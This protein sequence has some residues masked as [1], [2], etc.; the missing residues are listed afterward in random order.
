MSVSRRGFLTYLGIGSYAALTGQGHLASATAAAK[1]RRSKAPFFTPIAPSARDQLLLPRGFQYERLCSWDEPLGST[2]PLGPERFGFNNDLLVYFPIDALTGGQNPN[3]GLLWVNHEY[4]H[5]LLVSKF[6]GTLPKTEAQIIQEKLSVGGAVL[7]VRRHKGKWQRVA[8]SSHTRRFTALYPQIALSGP[9]AELVPHAIG[10]LA[11]CSGG[12]TPWNT[13]LSCEENFH[14]YNGAKGYRWSEVKG[15]AI[16]ERQYGWVVEVDPFGE[17]PPLKHSALGRFAHENTCWRIGPTGKLVVYMGDDAANQFLYKFVSAAPLQTNAPRAEQR[18]VLTVGTLYVAD[19]EKGQWLPL[20][21]ERRPALKDAGFKSQ[22]DV[23]LRARE[24]A[25][26]LRATPLDRPEDCEVHPLDGTLYVALTNNKSHGNLY[27]HILRLLEDYDNPE[28]ESFRFEI[29][30]AGGPQSG[31]AC[32]DN[33]CFDRKGNLWVACDISTASLNK[34]AYLPFGNNGLFFVPTRG[35]SAGD[36]FQ[37]ASGP[38][39][40][41]LTGP[42]FNPNEDTLFL[43]VQHPGENSKSLTELTSHWP[44]G[45][46]DLPRSSVVAITGF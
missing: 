33:L 23:L 18:Q 39:D 17:L 2:G 10:T 19:L 42:W 37:F 32:P 28:G 30:L 21:L 31:L 36:A 20:D 3:E 22:G 38:V 8:D 44:F 46:A 5:P 34:G 9:T 14:H 41:E 26:V 13:A 4:L 15:Q 1:P 27:G 45:G 24:A 7:H 12:I 16:D 25:V 6:D 40:C 35:P 43:S 11:N 29:F